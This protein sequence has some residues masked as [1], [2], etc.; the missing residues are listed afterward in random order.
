MHNNHTAVM[1]IV[2]DLLQTLFHVL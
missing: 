2:S 1:D